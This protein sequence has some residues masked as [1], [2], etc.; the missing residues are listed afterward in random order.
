[1]RLT[2]LVEISDGGL[3]PV[4]PLAADPDVGSVVTTDLLDPRRYLTGGELVLTGLAWWRPHRPGRSRGFV[5]ALVS[6][7]VVAMAA[8]EAELGDVPVDLVEACV[9]AGLPLL[10]VPVAVSFA[11][12]IEQATRHLSARRSG[13]LAAV[14][15]RHRA[16]MA[17][18]AV[19]TGG[20]G[21]SGVLEMVGTDLDLRC[22]VLSP[23]G[24]LIGGVAPIP[25][26]R[27]RRLFA[28]HYLRAPRLPYRFV[29]PG[30]RTVSLFAD[31]PGSDPATARVASWMVAVCEDH[32]GWSDDRR[33]VME[34]LTS[35]VALERDLSGRRSDVEHQLAAA[36]SGASA[37]EIAAAARRCGLDAT[38]AAVVVAGAGRAVVP[39]L[40]EALVGEATPWALGEIDGEALGIVTTGAPTDLAARLRAIVELLGPGLGPQPLRI[41]ISDA[42]T[43]GA[44]LLGGV[45]EA[46]AAAAA[47]GTT[48]GA[49]P[50]TVAGPDRLSSHALLL[51]AVPAELRDAYRRRVLGAVLEHD[52]AHRTDLV[53]TLE[54]YLDCS[55]SW[56]RC[57]SRMHLHVNT[58][59]YRIERIEALTGRD[60]RRL[61]DQADLLLAL[62]LPP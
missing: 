27:E 20:S 40:A 36:L 31:G 32:T 55:G 12:V 41:G 11:S 3:V 10:R 14:L 53:K 22:W 25:D 62:H 4:G 60:L 51:A 17:A 50:H 18:A 2:A 21:L 26:E 33:A 9:E 54:A 42:V 28:R 39:I 61:E 43:G 8:G 47:A 49:G 13:D 38:V 45:A 37:D 52:R 35:L 46:R 56:S 30:G 29:R 57:A 6:A 5:A 58:L 15:S 16:L 19:Q 34:E 59:R 24:R 1:M 48:I 7:G 44:G 23:T